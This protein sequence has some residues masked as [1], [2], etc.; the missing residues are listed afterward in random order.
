L[1]P[2]SQVLVSGGNSVYGLLARGTQLYIS[3][4]EGLDI[5]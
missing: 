3:A 4:P 2:N 1:L 5:Q